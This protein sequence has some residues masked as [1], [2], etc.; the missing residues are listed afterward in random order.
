M[1]KNHCRIKLKG[2]CM[3]IIVPEGKNK[4]SRRMVILEEIMI[5]YFPE[6]G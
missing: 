3:L 5:K 2:L 4:E 1:G 6:L